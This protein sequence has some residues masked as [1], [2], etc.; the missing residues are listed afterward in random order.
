M[1]SSAAE[2][3]GMV[4]TTRQHH[5]LISPLA[6]PSGPRPLATIVLPCHNEAG[7]VVRELERITAAMDASGVSYELLVVDDAS[8]DDSPRLLREA[9]ARFPRMRLMPFRRNAG[10]GAA[11]RIGTS[12][13][14]GELVA[15]TAADLSYPNE[16]LPELIRYLV[17][18][19][20]CAQVVGDRTGGQAAGRARRKPAAWFA[21]RL[22]ER[23][24]GMSIADLDSGMRAFRRDLALPLLSHLPPRD[25]A[26]AAWTLAFLTGQYDVDYMPIEFVHRRRP[27]RRRPLRTAHHYVAH[28]GRLLVSF[29]PMKVLFPSAVGLVLIG[30]AGLVVD[31]ALSPLSLGAGFVG[32]A[33]A[34]VV[35]GAVALLAELVVR[36]RH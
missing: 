11:R 2:P 27:W 35:L 19:P 28:L 34:G 5:T 16:R 1:A 9:L 29:E 20:G 8:T 4:D 26:S 17:D 22:A 24:G 7:N 36:A 33:L 32:L 6:G 12:E 14:R 13:A 10:A 21:H 25:G 23:I 31:L 30:V 15:W 18:H 3:V